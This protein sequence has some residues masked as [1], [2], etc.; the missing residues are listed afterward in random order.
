MNQPLRLIDRLQAQIAEAA[1][2]IQADCLRTELG[3]YLARQGQFEQADAQVRAVRAR[4]EQA[5]LAATSVWLAIYDAL[6]AYFS[7][8]ELSAA[9]HKLLRAY[10]MSDAAR[11]V[12]LNALCAAWLAQLEFSEYRAESMAA[13]A[14]YLQQAFKQSSPDN[15]RVRVRACLTVATAY[16]ASGAIDTARRWFDKTRAHALADGDQGM[17]SALMHNMAALRLDNL[18]QQIFANHLEVDTDALSLTDKFSVENYDHLVGVASLGSWVPILRAQGLV[19]LNE[20]QRAMQIFEQQLEAT[21]QQGL[22]RRRGPLLAD[23]AWCHARLGRPELARSAAQ[24]ARER[25][26]DGAHHLDD[27]AATHSRLALTYALLGDAQAELH[28]GRLA[29]QVWTEYAAFQARVVEL[30][31]PIKAFED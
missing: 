8:L 31:E 30:L 3:V 13:M 27:V 20:P 23:M 28:H 6:R 5:P 26:V 10:A 7:S 22:L 25:L 2:P 14:V 4:H 12:E 15:H 16:Q 11:F 21:D 1:D 9:R 19:L 29:Q 24:Q 18:R 17:I